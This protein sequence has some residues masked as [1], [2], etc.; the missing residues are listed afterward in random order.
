MEFADSI[1]ETSANHDKW[2]EID[3]SAVAHNLE[4]VRER[5]QA[6]VRLIAVLKA[7][8]YGHGAVGT[9]VLMER[10][11][12]D[13]FAV[14]HLAE[15]LEL[16]EAGIKGEILLFLPLHQLEHI[17]CAAAAGLVLSIGSRQDWEALQ[18]ATYDDDPGLRLH[19]QVDTGLGRFGFLNH[20]ELILVANSIKESRHRLSGMYTHM[21]DAAG[22]PGYTRQQFE[23]FQNTSQAVAAAGVKI[24]LHHC[25]NS[26]VL[27][28]Y[29][30]MQLDAVRIGTLLSGQLP[31]GIAD[32]SLSLIDPFRFKSRIIALRRLASGSYLGYYRTYRLKRDAYLAVIPVGY[33]DGLL[34]EVANRPGS[35]LDLLKTMVRPLL[36]RWG[37]GRFQPAILW[38]GQHFPLRGKIF[39]QMALIEFP[40]SSEVSIGDVVEVPVRKVLVSPELPRIYVTAAGSRTTV[41]E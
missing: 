30:E 25:A 18:L 39:M 24:P 29:P 5:L 26:A 11:G 19:L 12:V 3:I 32:T 4:Q 31:V 10:H 23:R 40:L 37:W 21:A 27:L 7:D 16:R 33:R 17:R 36:Q 28:N 20:D 14:S 35:W 15:A 2:V 13:F 22:N 34:L 41:A 8:A 9:A 1:Q 38:R 6:D